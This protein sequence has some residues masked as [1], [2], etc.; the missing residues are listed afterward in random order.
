[1]QPTVDALVICDAVHRDPATNKLTLLGLFNGIQTTQLPA[2]IEQLCL[3]IAL[4]GIRSKAEITVKMV[5]TNP[6]NGDEEAGY[7]A[8]MTVDAPDGPLS[9]TE[10]VIPF[11]NL[12]LPHD[13]EYIFALEWQ[14]VRIAQRKLWVKV[15]P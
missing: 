1:M 3:F 9:G 2:S 6:S 12:N 8:V 11:P 13:G 4:S 14:G 15:V 7:E 5:W 10:G